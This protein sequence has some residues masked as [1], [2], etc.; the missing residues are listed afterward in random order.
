MPDVSAPENCVIYLEDLLVSD[1]VSATNAKR[2]FMLG[3]HEAER[4]MLSNTF[5]WAYTTSQAHVKST[6]ELTT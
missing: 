3:M 1:L 6:I 4:I 2:Y 5:N